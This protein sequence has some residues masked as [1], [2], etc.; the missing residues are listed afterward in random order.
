MN[1]EDIRKQLEE[2]NKEIYFNKLKLDLTNNLEVLVLT[3]DNLLNNME[4]NMK[5]RILN[6]AESFQNEKII[7]ENIREFIDKYKINLMTLLDDKKNRLE[8]LFQDK[9]DINDYKIYLDDENKKINENISNYYIQNINSLI[10][11]I[12][13]LYEDEFSNLRIKEYLK[14][15]LNSELEEKIMD[16][17][18]S[19]D[20]ILLNTFKET[21]MKY[22]ELNKNTIGIKN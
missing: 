7:K 14:N 13:K 2:K 8:N 10:D 6:I 18:N 11:N 9:K 5:D 17:I 12:T 1:E 16:T 19:R 21:Y 20:I 15:V 3:I 4:K 22:L